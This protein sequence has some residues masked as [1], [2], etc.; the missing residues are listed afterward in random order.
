[1]NLLHLIPSLCKGG[2]ERLVLD[3]CRELSQREGIRCKLV[4]MYEENEYPHLTRGVDIVFCNSRVLPSI[5]G[6]WQIDI[7]HWKHIVQEFQP[8]I[9]HSHLFEAEIMSRYWIYSNAEY[10]TH[11][12]SNMEQL[13]SIQLKNIFNKRNLTNYYE[14]EFLLKK[15]KE[16]GNYFISISKN[17]TSYFYKILPKY[18]TKNIFLLPNAINVSNFYKQKINSSNKLEL[19]T[20]GTL[21]NNKNQVYLLEVMLNL[22]KLG[23]DANLSIIGD[24][25]QKSFLQEFIARNELNSQV[26]I[27]GKQ[28]DIPDFLSRAYIYIHAAKSEAFGLVLLEAM[29]SGLPVITLDGGGNRDLIEEG[30]NGYILPQETSPNA[31]AQKIIELAKDKELYTKFSEHAIKYAAQYDIKPYADRLILLY[32]KALHEKNLIHS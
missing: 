20:I 10:F 7:A 9:I 31:F 23:I 11:G 3:T 4:V 5:K 12:H 13:S 28:N 30:K 24:G 16:A 18:L 26:K 15:Y 29:A 17:T 2:A 14:R 25:D 22:K 8:D 21:N 32:Q 1:M 27:F 6:K 19:V